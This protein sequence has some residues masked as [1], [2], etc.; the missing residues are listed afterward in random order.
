MLT[1]SQTQ[2]TPLAQNSP[3]SPNQHFLHTTTSMM[4]SSL[5]TNQLQNHLNN[6]ASSILVN[7]VH[8]QAQPLST[9][10]HTSTTSNNINNNNQ[11]FDNLNFSN[12]LM[13]QQPPALTSLSSSSLVVSTT[14]S[15]G[16]GNGRKCEVKLNA[17][18]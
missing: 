14:S 7:N 9:S 1:N 16:G 8:L 17:M 12:A 6:G 18:P 10:M 2:T 13:S 5:N 11:N 4:T 3:K 15:V